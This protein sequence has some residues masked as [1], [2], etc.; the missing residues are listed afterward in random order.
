[1]ENVTRWPGAVL[2]ESRLA[3][4]T[5]QNGVVI[6][7][8]EAPCWEAR[9][10]RGVRQ[11]YDFAPHAAC[12]RTFAETLTPEAQPDSDGIAAY[13]H[14]R[15]LRFIRRY[16]VLSESFGYFGYVGEACYLRIIAA[17]WATDG[18]RSVVAGAEAVDHAWR[19][20]GHLLQRWAP[21]A[22]TLRDR[23]IRAAVGHL[24]TGVA[25]RRCDGCGNW[26]ALEPQQRRYCTS[27][28]RSRGFQ[29][30]A[31]GEG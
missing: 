25:M 31:K 1:M 20:A 2:R 21:A 17:A 13:D 4:D 11:Q 15:L 5:L 30:R 23:M 3:S 8:H 24:A 27:A 18:E 10:G 9:P 19:R 12:W 28:C 6:E 22:D 29:R 26:L 16:G 7:H 14:D